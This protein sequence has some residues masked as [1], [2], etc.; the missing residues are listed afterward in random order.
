MDS[1]T[2]LNILQDW[3]YWDKPIPESIERDVDL[4]LEL[5]NDLV[6]VIQG[7]RRAGK[8][9]L[10]TQLIDRYDLDKKHCT[11]VNFEESRLSSYLSYE[12]LQN[13]VDAVRAEN[14]GQKQYYFF[15]DE[16]QNIDGFEKWLH[17]QLERPNENHFVITGS[18][19]SL[20]SGELGSKLTG[21]HLTVTLYPFSFNEFRRQ[22]PKK[23]VDDYIELGGF[24]RALVSPDRERLLGEY[25][26]NI[27][28]RDIRE[29]VKA[30]SALPLHE[31]L[32]MV[33]ESCGSETSLRK[34]AGT[35]GLTGD[36][37]GRYLEMAESAYIIQ[38]CP[39]FTHSMKQQ[40]VRN[41]KYYPIDTALRAR[42]IIQGG[43]DL[44]K[45]LELLVFLHLKKHHQQVYYWR[46]TG[47]VDFVIKDKN[48]I[49]P[50][51]VS[52]GDIKPRHEDA[53]VEFYGQFPMANEAV[54]INRDNCESW[55]L[56][57]KV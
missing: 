42:V 30:R 51:Q 55:L 23:T 33:F 53:L 27:I 54:F 48:G 31:L 13:I 36:T 49:T 46:G 20:L 22:F 52:W 17:T 4:P 39:F 11:F 47:E 14:P 43:K 37:V 44:G 29:R 41:K 5:S 25:F 8:S 21:R 16:I 24:P 38:S 9:T 15:F 45:A 7:V 3:S 56:S 12:L 50:Y 18:N 2:L 40:V 34:L 10:L 57:G 35:S 32:Q 6:L 1:N 19:A 28:E 26:S